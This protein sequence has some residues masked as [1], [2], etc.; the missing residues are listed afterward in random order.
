MGVVIGQHLF[1]CRSNGLGPHGSAD[2]CHRTYS[3]ARNRSRFASTKAIA[4]RSPSSIVT[5]GDQPM[6][7]ARQAVV[8]HELADL[9]E[10]GPHALLLLHDGLVY[11]HQV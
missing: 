9:A 7:L 4:C 8:G 10:L 1:S 6:T 3:S 5:L 2:R 11:A